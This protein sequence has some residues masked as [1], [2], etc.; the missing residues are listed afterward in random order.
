MNFKYEFTFGVTIH[1]KKGDK[2]FFL[3][4]E[5]FSHCPNA[6]FQLS[7]AIHKNRERKRKERLVDKKKKK[8]K[9]QT[10]NAILG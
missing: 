8:K 5:C 10:V 7:S 3:D 2:M 9:T 6:T 4:L 1:L